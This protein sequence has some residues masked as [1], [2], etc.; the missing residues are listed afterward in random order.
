MIFSHG[1]KPDVGALCV[2]GSRCHVFIPKEKWGKLNTHL[3]DGTFSG[4]T[5]KSKAYKILVPSHHKFITSRDVIVYKNL[6]EHKN[7]PII[8]ITPSKGVSQD[9]S[10]SSKGS[11]EPTID[12]S[13]PDLKA[14]PEQELPTTPKPT[15][16]VETPNQPIQPCHSEYAT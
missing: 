16:A 10:A 14:I 9:Q 1:K 12:I 2:F 15:P 7:E 11:T 3:V 6:P 5:P 4:Y 13:A 8:T